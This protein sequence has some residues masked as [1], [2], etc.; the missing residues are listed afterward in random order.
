MVAVGYPCSNQCSGGV[1]IP[2]S[3]SLDEVT[4]KYK[5]FVPEQLK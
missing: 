5:I 4:D 1:H 2:E 3:R